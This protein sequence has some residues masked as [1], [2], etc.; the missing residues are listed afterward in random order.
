MQSRT[1]SAFP[2]TI[3]LPLPPDSSLTTI[4]AFS[5]L[6]DSSTYFESFVNIL[7]V[8][9]FPVAGV[10]GA[11]Y[12]IL[13][14]GDPNKFAWANGVNWA[15]VIGWVIGCVI[16]WFWA[17]LGM[18]VGFL[19]AGAVYLVLYKPLSGKEE[20]QIVEGVEIEV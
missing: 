10:I 9:F 2:A 19:A 8:F 20:N 5:S 7:G 6:E 15:G 11:D 3:F 18:I 1:A 12:W 13:R 16:S 14:K 17:G 4:S